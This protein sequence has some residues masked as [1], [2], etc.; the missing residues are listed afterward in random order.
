MHACGVSWRI[1]SWL[2]A[3]EEKGVSKKSEYLGM[4]IQAR[5]LFAW[6]FHLGVSKVLSR[7]KVFKFM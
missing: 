5:F 6:F 7:V 4:H 1:P 3:G 2:N